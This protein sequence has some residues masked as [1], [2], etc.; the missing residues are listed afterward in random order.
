MSNSTY[1]V[2]FKRRGFKKPYGFWFP[3]PEERDSFFQQ[4][5]QEPGIYGIRKKDK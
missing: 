5:R 1:G 3:T 2:I 4:K